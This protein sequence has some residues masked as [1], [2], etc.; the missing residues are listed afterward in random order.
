MW[1][2]GTSMLCNSPTNS[3]SQTPPSSSSNSNHSLLLWLLVCTMFSKNAINGLGYQPEGL[4]EDHTCVSFTWS[5]HKI[6][7]Q[8]QLP[9]IS[10]VLLIC[11]WVITLNTSRTL[12]PLTHPHPHTHNTA[13]VQACK[14]Y[15]AY[16]TICGDS[17]YYMCRPGL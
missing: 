9:L 12:H 8:A 2:R 13:R 11:R 3:L 1:T 17:N 14:V 7:G 4:F 6:M 5:K 16:R 15:C 10:W